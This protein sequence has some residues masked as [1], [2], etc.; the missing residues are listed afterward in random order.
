MSYYKQTEQWL[1]TLLGALPN[2]ERGEAKKSIKA[3]L[4][5]SYRNG[6]RAEKK[7]GPAV[8][9]QKPVIFRVEVSEWPA[10]EVS[11]SEPR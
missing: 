5:E 2:G 11:T 1:D 8:S 7:G 6:E 10:E 3:K 4:L 9:G